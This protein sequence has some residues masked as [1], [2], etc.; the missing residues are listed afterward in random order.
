MDGAIYC[1]A[2]HTGDG[3][4]SCIR[5]RPTGGVARLDGAR[6]TSTSVFWTVPSHGVRGAPRQRSTYGPPTPARQR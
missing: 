3:R 6:S 2:R 1:L 5:H 4:L